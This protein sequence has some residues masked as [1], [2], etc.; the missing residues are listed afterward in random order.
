M[1]FAL[2]LQSVFTQVIKERNRD[3][4]Q[5]FRFR[6][7]YAEESKMNR[8]AK[9]ILLFTIIALILSLSACSEPERNDTGGDTDIGGL[10]WDILH[11][12]EGDGP[13]P[14]RSFIRQ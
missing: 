10:F 11:G 3:S 9:C 14:E 2:Y 4:D 8:S 5:P 13:A 12:I 1:Q 7:Y 6:D